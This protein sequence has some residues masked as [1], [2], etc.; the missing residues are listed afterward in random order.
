[1]FPEMIKQLIP[2]IGFAWTMRAVTLVILVLSAVSFVALR[3]PPPNPNFRR[4]Q[5]P[6]DIKDRFSAL[7]QRKFVLTFIGVSFFIS[8]YFLVLIFVATVARL[9]GWMDPVDAIVCLNGAR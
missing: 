6:K 2:Q 1:M 5:P 3:D 8:G 4:P 7:A 9:R